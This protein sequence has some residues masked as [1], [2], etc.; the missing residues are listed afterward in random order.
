MLR[1]HCHRAT[2]E[3]VPPEYVAVFYLSGGRAPQSINADLA[4]VRRRFILEKWRQ[5]DFPSGSRVV[6]YKCLG[7]RAVPAR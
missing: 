1:R 2:R 5:Q 3:K 6:T 4:K 7:K